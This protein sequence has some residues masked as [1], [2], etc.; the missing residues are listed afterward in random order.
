MVP[1]GAPLVLAKKLVPS[2][3]AV[4]PPNALVV[5]TNLSA[6]ATLKSVMVSPPSVGASAASEGV[7]GRKAGEGVVAGTAVEVVSGSIAGEA[8]AEI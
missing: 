2:I 8:V 4:M 5:N 6:S 1:L 3:T 7:F